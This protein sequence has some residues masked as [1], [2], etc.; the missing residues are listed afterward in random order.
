MPPVST[1]IQSPETEVI[2]GGVDYSFVTIRLTT[3][4]EG[5][6]SCVLLCGNPCTTGPSPEEFKQV[7]SLLCV[8]CCTPSV[9][10]FDSFVV[11]VSNTVY[12]TGN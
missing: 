7:H 6:W 9:T 12:E 5:E 8:T 10:I 3:A 4:E 1:D 2:S 11:E